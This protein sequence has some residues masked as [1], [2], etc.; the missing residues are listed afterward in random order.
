MFK[1]RALVLSDRGFFVGQMGL[2]Q[3]VHTLTRPLRDRN[4]FTAK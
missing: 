1:E 2:S 3:R 4:T